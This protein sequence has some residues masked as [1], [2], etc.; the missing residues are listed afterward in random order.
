MSAS[1]LLFSSGFL[2]GVATTLVLLAWL[3]R[4]GQP[5]SSASTRSEVVSEVLLHD[6]R[7]R[8]Q[9]AELERYMKRRSVKRRRELDRAQ[10][11]GWSR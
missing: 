10:R 5:K 11:H 3:A 1:V 2:F 8:R 6:A 7:R 9:L 4:G